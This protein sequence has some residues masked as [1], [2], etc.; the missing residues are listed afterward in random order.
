[1]PDFFYSARTQSGQAISGSLT[2]ADRKAALAQ[3][4]AQG[5]FPIA[6]DVAPSKKNGAPAA[7]KPKPGAIAAAKPLSKPAGKTGAAPVKKGRITSRHVM[8]FTQQL[9]NLLKSGM[10]IKQALDSLA[11]QQKG[12]AFGALLEQVAEEIVQGANLSDALARHPRVF[13][14]FYT[15]MIR[16]GEQSGTL[17]DVLARLTGHYERMAEIREKVTS[18][19]LYPAIVLIVGIGVVFVFMVFMLPR[20]TEM[21]QGLGISLPLATRVLIAVGK[22]AGNIWFL[23]GL[24]AVVTL[25]VIAYKRAMSTREG[26]LALDRIRL[27]LPLFGNT[28]KAA[29]FA[30]FSRTLATLLA[31]GVPVLTALKIAEDTMT[32]LVLAQESARARERVP[33]GTTISAP[34][35]AGQ[36][37]PP[38]LIDMLAIGE[39]TGD[40]PTALNNVAGLYEQQLTQDV[41]RFTTLLE[42]VVIVMI[43]LVVGSIV[44]SVLSAVMS[45]TSGLR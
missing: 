9:A 17:P 16:A 19:L 21:F 13:T 25:V 40:V 15:N 23:L 10:S 39:Q 26:R 44:F 37:F 43:A 30:Q 11:R 3:L 28:L 24:A 41:R 45:I 2:A 8:L 36:I 34:L 29:L 4:T 42:P 33:D 6:V 14:R 7:A 20:F 1:M 32:N 18:A 31:N 27:R 38:L 35:A 22:T 5:Y 12:K